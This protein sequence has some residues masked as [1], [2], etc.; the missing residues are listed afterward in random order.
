[1]EQKGNTV[2]APKAE[3]CLLVRATGI[4]SGLVVLLAIAALA[5]PIWDL[6][7][8][9]VETGPWIGVE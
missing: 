4:V 8:I 5:R 2:L 1:L 7:S 9:G 3:P 6:L